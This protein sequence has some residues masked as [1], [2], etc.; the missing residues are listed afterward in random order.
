MK[1]II[2]LI[3]AGLLLLTG[4][5]TAL[6][7]YTLPAGRVQLTAG[8]PLP[9]A[10][11]SRRYNTYPVRSDLDAVFGS[12]DHEIFFLNNDKC[13]QYYDLSV[14][15]SETYCKL[16]GCT[17]LDE[18][19]AAYYGGA[20][21]GTNY[22]V[23]GE[24]VY[25]AP[26]SE[27]SES[28]TLTAMNILTGEKQTLL[29]RSVDKGHYINPPSLNFTGNSL[30]VS[31]SD[32]LA[33]THY[34]GNAQ[35]LDEETVV[36]HILRCDL[37]TGEVREL[38]NDELPNYGGRALGTTGVIMD[39]GDRYAL[40]RSGVDFAQPPMSVAEF[41]RDGGTEEAYGNYVSE[42]ETTGG[43]YYLWDLES[44]EMTFLYSEEDDLTDSSLAYNRHTVCFARGNAVWRV[45]LTDGSVTELFT[46]DT[47]VVMTEQWDGR[48][49]YNTYTDGIC[50][51]YWYEL[52]TGETHQFQKGT[53]L[54][55]FSIKAETPNYFVGLKGESDDCT[56]Y[57]LSKQD[58]YNENFAAA[59]A[60]G[61]PS[62]LISR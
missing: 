53:S 18:N 59:Q 1:R 42:L 6:P 27:D 15:K 3:A 60:I 24:Y 31:Y 12:T 5:S 34:E 16:P 10:E 41:V 39:A 40:Y 11:Q 26:L 54:S 33:V 44:G 2:A 28:F 7:E 55:V 14:S 19:C 52:A 47:P 62:I 46:T 51:W 37:L 61:S 30:I 8:N 17:H 20:V 36:R 4:C 35:I 23:N 29:T 22:T 38:V 50:S 25:A 49:F 32:I 56:L 21:W 45:D 13:A 58:Y 48:V 9:V 43:D 57:A